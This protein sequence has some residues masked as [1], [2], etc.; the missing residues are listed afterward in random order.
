MFKAF[1]FLRKDQPSALSEL[2]SK[3][4]KT[5]IAC[6]ACGEESSAGAFA[7]SIM[8]CP[9]CGKYL[10][11]GARERIAAVTD[12][13]SFNE[14][15][16]NIRSVDFLHFPDYAEKLQKAYKSTSETEGV[17]VGTAAIGGE[18]CALFIMDSRFI[19]ASMGSAIG[20]RLVRLFEYACE[21]RLPV[22]GFTASGGARM[23]EGIVS[24][25]QMAKVSGAVKR[26]SNLG[27][28]YITVLTDPTTGGVTASF[29]MQGDIIL[30]EPRALVGFAGRRVI[31]QTM[32]SKLPDDFQSAEFLLEHGFVDAIVTRDRQRQVISTLLR[33]H[34]GREVTA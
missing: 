11:M 34:R 31:E 16:G 33:Q 32:H 29:A 30:A 19:M 12:K 4:G 20:E 28:L 15:F 21:N 10:R 24:L 17:V 18:K 22:V 14:M 27:L 25:M 8:V 13:Y 23:Q 9:K 2:L 3:S 6:T 26:H 5:K 7:D 1:T